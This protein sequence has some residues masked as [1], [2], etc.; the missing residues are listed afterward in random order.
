SDLVVLRTPLLPFEEMEAWSAGLLSPGYEEHDEA[1]L[2]Q[3]IAHDRTLLRERLRVLIERPEIR[4]ALAL[5]SPDL[6]AGL[7]HWQQAPESRKGRRAE[8]ALVRY[9]LRMVSR[10][11]PFGLF[12]GWTAGTLGE[13]TRLELAERGACRR[14]SRLD[15]FY[16]F[17]LW[18]LL[19]R[20]PGLRAETLFRPNSSLYEA[21]GR[22]RY[23]EARQ[24]LHVRRYHLVAVESFDAL[25]ETL[26]RAAAGARLQELAEALVA[27]DP[28]V[29]L[30]DATAFLHD[31]VDSQILVPDP[32]LPLT[33]EETTPALLRQLAGLPSL[34]EVRE[35]LARAGRELADLDA[36]GLGADPQRYPAIARGLEPLGAPVDLW[37]MV[38]V[39]LIKPA[40]E[41]V[42]G[43]DVADEIR[44]GVDVLHRICPQSGDPATLVEFRRAFRERYGEGREM[45]LLEVLDEE[46][47]IGFGRLTKA[48]ADASPLLAE[49]R[50][51]PRHQ[52]SPVPWSSR[53]NHLLG[54]L[55]DA[56][57]QGRMEV[58]LTES[59]LETLAAPSQYPLQDALPDAF[60]VSVAL[61]NNRI[62]LEHAWGPSGARL[63]G[64][65]CHLDERIDA[66]VRAHLAAEEA[67][68][69]EAI[70]AEI[71]H[72]PTGRVGNLLARPVLRSYEI[73]Y[74]GVSGAPRERQIPVQD[75]TVTVEGDRVRLRSRSLGREVVP[76][77]TA[78]LSTVYES[79]GLYRL[80]GALQEQGRASHLGWSWTPLNKVPFLPR[81][82]L[83]R[84]VLSRARWLVAPEEI[85]PLARAR[86][87]LGAARCRLARRWRQERRIPRF[88]LQVEA[89]NAL[90]LD[91]DNPLCLDSF[92]ELVKGRTE[93]VLTEPFPAPDGLGAVHGPEGR[94]FHEILVLFA[95]RPADRPAAPLP[96]PA[97][98]TDRS[99]PPGSEWLD[100]RIHTGTGTAD[101]ILRD[102]IAPLVREARSW[103]FTRE[104]D[105]LRVC[106]RGDP[107]RLYELVRETFSRLASTGAAWRCRLDTYEREVERFGG[108][109]GIE[110]AEEVFHHDS[111][112][113]LELLGALAGDESADLRWHL[114]L[115]GIDRLLDDF[116]YGL[117]DRR[118]LIEREHKRLADGFRYSALRGVLARRLRRDRPLLESLLD[119]RIEALERRSQAIAGPLRELRECASRGLLSRPLDDL[120]PAFLHGFVNRLG[121]SAATEHET[122]LYDYLNRLYRSRMTRR[123]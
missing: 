115:Q 118:R 65:L 72:L 54:L 25:K 98:R 29:D 37:R 61:G 32:G 12:A 106:L 57:A 30:E 20:H 34:A 59:D 36:G 112:A 66:G 100:V 46:I 110:L 82:V 80:M 96:A 21:A 44:R 31:L 10:P 92:V 116:G 108:D 51:Y 8:H 43:R 109:E 13:R 47:G 111:E 58:E 99:F 41:A 62:L 14:H 97:A 52:A 95:R 45:P 40:R 15:M 39:D 6:L 24:Y 104:T 19:R 101:A 71:V 5:A 90:L 113:V 70:Y 91:L 102:E 81:V 86:D 77:L 9:L 53:E 74:L 18:D 121:R 78:S 28:E 69:P 64:R 93:I 107:G 42:L 87:A 55:T 67:H 11:T 114:M 56:L 94:F 122:V 123:G 38:Q 89:E 68:A 79:L 83:G 23:A 73:P 1:G 85:A 33:G 63:I 27:G 60:A 4:E 48:S 103:F 17:R 3:A 76:R 84:L 22:L 16:L 2:A 88:V 120:V 7:R 49:L 119:Q 117:E 75:L 35:R 50:F 105:H 26:E